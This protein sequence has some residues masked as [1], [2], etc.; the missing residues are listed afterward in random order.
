LAPPE[1]VNNRCTN[2]QFI[3]TGANSPVPALCGTLTGQHSMLTLKNRLNNFITLLQIVNF[4]GNFWQK[5]FKNSDHNK[6]KNF[7]EIE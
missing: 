2:D 4:K 1:G 6:T 5:W 7:V 3:I